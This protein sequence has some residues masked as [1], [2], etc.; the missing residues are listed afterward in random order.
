MLPNRMDSIMPSAKAGL[1]TLISTTITPT[2]PPN[3]QRPVS[4]LAAVTGSVAMKTIPKAK[5]PMVRCQNQGTENIGLLSLPIRLNSVEVRTI[6]A[7]TPSMI[8]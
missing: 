3:I 6:P 2:S 8:L 1:I 5:P 7:K 4:V